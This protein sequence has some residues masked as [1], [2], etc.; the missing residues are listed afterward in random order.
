MRSRAVSYGILEAVYS[1]EML[2]HF[3]DSSTSRPAIRPELEGSNPKTC[4]P[5]SSTTQRGLCC[6]EDKVAPAGTTEGGEARR[7]TSS[8]SCTAQGR[9]A[10]SSPRVRGTFWAVIRVVMVEGY[11]VLGILCS[12]ESAGPC[13]ILS[14]RETPRQRRDGKRTSCSPAVA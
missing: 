2:P 11:T 9:V 13:Y 10:D 8:E 12:L 7:T 5:T 3:L 14:W 4:G 1:T 6:P